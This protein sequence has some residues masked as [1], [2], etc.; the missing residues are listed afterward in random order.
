M[1]NIVGEG[2]AEWTRQQIDVRQ[3]VYGSADRN[4]EKLTFLNARTGWVKLI[5][6]VDVKKVIRSLPASKSGL[7]SNFVLFNGVTRESDNFQ[8][9][10]VWPG[11]GDFNDYA[12]GVG[13][14]EF[15]LRPMPG[16]LNASIKTET[17]GSLKTA[18][19]TIRANSREQFDIID[20]LYLRLGF[21]MLL[22]WGH[23]SYFNNNGVYV[24]NPRHS[25][26][27]AFLTKKYAF[28][29]GST[30]VNY[31]TM[32]KAIQEQREASNGNYDAIVGKVVN[33]NWTFTKDGS[34]EITL[35]LRSLGDVIESLKTNILLPGGTFSTE[36]PN[37]QSSGAAAT[38]IP[39]QTTPPAPNPDQVIKEFANKNEIARDFYRIQQSLKNKPVD[40]F[41][42]ATATAYSTTTN[43]DYFKQNYQNGP[44]QYYVRFGR[45]LEFIQGQIIPKVNNKAINLLNIDFNIENNIILLGS[46]YQIPNDPRIC[47]YYLTFNKNTKIIA[48]GCEDFRFTYNGKIYG[49][50]MNAYFNMAWIL[51]TMDSLKDDKGKVNLYD[52]LK[53]LCDGW[54]KSTGNFSQIEPV[55]DEETNTVKIIDQIPLPDR[56]HFLET[57][58]LPATPAYFDIFGYNGKTIKDEKGNKSN[59]VTA[60]FV[61]EFNF[62]TTI[63][64]NLATM[65]TVGS[66][67]NGYVVGQDSTALS[68]MN[69]GLEDRFKIEINHTGSAN[70]AE[71]ANSASVEQDY[72]ESIADYNKYVNNLAATSGNSPKW[73]TIAIDSF[74]E[75]STQLIEYDQAKQ[76]Q[77]AQNS[78]KAQNKIGNIA[79][80]NAGFLPFDLSLDMDGIS[81]MKVYQSFTIDTS[82]LPSNYPNSLEFLIKGVTHTIQNNEW[83]T[84]IDSMAIPK[85]PFGSG[86]KE[87][88]VESTIQ[89]RTP[90]NTGTPL[91]NI[92]QYVTDNTL[93]DLSKFLYPTTGTVTSKVTVRAP[94]AGGV[95]G[96]DQHRAMD[97]G[98]VKGTPVYS[99]TAGKVVK[100][101]ASGYGP[102]AVY[103]QIDKSYY[104]DPSKAAKNPFY[105]IYG[106]MDTT[107]VKLNQ[108]VTVGQQIGTVGDKDSVGK[109]HLHYQIKSNLGYDSAG[110]SINTNNN[111]PA[112]SSSITAKQK[113]ITA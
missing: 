20:L 96:S 61:R 28:K 44:T 83:L 100:I 51:T 70:S 10:G 89:R 74:S 90:V 53:A 101:G 13:G 57:Q 27:D 73:D 85:N 107:L 22:E 55:V 19:V 67:A 3:T 105:I 75:T 41:G 91:G 92:P 58:T 59:I 54:N 76:T 15:G 66:T 45:F 18:N 30:E 95:K 35:T 2:F 79:S 60:G 14:T 108:I 102:N 80:P 39:N 52:I 64:N 94:I 36:T 21:N 81:G 82:Y 4:N 109:F 110:I 106:H 71:T 24:A 32:L 34:Y 77:A 38:A 25:L 72:K 84:Q 87:D 8:R 86:A 33:F 78:E 7:A 104:L 48:N 111:F 29:D 42:V 5:S 62:Q 99:S 113:F 43:I 63:T 68:R 65:L 88:T 49:K 9:S 12:Y 1:G 112:K 40:S 97:I 6:S 103:I 11:T 16:I 31:Q 17:R 37:A 47:T 46:Q 93:L 26:A 50:I 23:S 98:A 56:T 69:D